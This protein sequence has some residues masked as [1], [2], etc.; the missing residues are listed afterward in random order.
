MH[1]SNHIILSIKPKFVKLLLSGS[2]QFELRSKIGKKFNP[3]STVYIYSSS[4]E[5]ALIAKTS[6]KTVQ[7]TEK[8]KITDEV[9]KKIC[10]KRD[11]FELYM[12]NK[13]NFCYLIEFKEFE[14]FNE[15]IPLS[16]LKK[17]S[18]TAPQSFCYANKVFEDFIQNNL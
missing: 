3:D 13:G 2:K 6:I 5:K 11:F 18:F 10:I 9:L 16:V 17:I 7:I 14:I 12:E 4:P 15:P 1:T 8:N